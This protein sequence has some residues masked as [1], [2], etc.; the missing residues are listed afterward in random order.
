MEECGLDALA[1]S[2]E[3][4][5]AGFAGLVVEAGRARTLD[6]LELLVTGRGRELL[7]GV[8]QHGLDAQAAAEVRLPRVTGADG[9]ARTR[10]ER[11]HARAVVTTVGPVRVRRIACRAKVK[12]VPALF[13]RDAVLSLPPRGYSWP[14]QQLAVMCARD[15]AYELAREFVR[16]VTAVTIGKRRL[17]EI[18]A[19]A[20]DG[21]PA[22][23]AGA[24]ALAGRAGRG[25]GGAAGA[26][27]GRQGRGDAAGIAA[28]ADQGAGQAGEELRHASWHRGERPQA[29]RR[30]RVR[31]R[32]DPPAPHP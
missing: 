21:V 16:A 28:Q 19:A 12:G 11:D 30:D 5:V 7:R 32:R 14:L 13:P 6:A 24:R 18:V 2:A 4:L 22:F 20:A 9:V 29:D 23:Y 17:G 27:G 8:I 3:S 15:G 31:V 26:A 10:A 25:S 1:A